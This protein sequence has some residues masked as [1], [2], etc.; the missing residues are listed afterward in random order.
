MPFI[1]IL[2]QNEPF[3]V[4][5]TPGVEG[6]SGPTAVTVT[7]LNSTG[8][9]VRDIDIF[10]FQLG[11]PQFVFTRVIPRNTP[12]LYIEVDLPHEG[13]AQVRVRQ[14]TLIHTTDILFDSRLV[15]DVV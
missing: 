5:V 3:T 9:S 8:N 14:G 15:F 13:A 7:Y 12:R 4:D 6:N 1:G 11:D 10:T 2:Q